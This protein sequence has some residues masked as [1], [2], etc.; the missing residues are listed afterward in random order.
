MAALRP[1]DTMVDPALER[2][3]PNGITVYGDQRV[4]TCFEQ[5]LQR[6]PAL[7]TDRSTTVDVPEDQQ[8][9]IPLRHD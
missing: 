5:V 6:Y 3:L 1:S 9:P 8:M 4:Q 2:K 7:F